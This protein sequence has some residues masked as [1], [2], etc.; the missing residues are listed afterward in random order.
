[1]IPDVA[2][3][4]RTVMLTFSGGAGILSCDLL[5]RY[6]LNVAQL[7]EKTID[8]L[9]NIFPEWMPAANPVD[10]YPAMELHGRDPTY[11]QAISIALEDPNVDVI[12]VH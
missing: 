3:T 7:T 12:I 8:A 1:M 5:E 2:P 4:C 11:N 6:G 9:G 10:L